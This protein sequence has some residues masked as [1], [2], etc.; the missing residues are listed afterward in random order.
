MSFYIQT[1]LY[2][3]G[4]AS[5]ASYTPDL[6]TSNTFYVNEGGANYY[7]RTQM[8]LLFDDALTAWQTELNAATPL[9]GTYSVSYD[10][11]TNRVTI[12]SSVAF[13]LGFIGN[14]ATIL[15][16]SSNSYA[17]ATSRTGEQVPAGKIK[18]LGRT[19]APAEHGEQVEVRTYRHQRALSI[20]W[21][22][23]QIFKIKLFFT[24][25]QVPA[26]LPK[27]ADDKAG[28]CLTGK[29][30]ITGLD[31]AAYSATNPDGFTEGYV[32]TTGDLETAGDTEGFYSMQMVLGV[33]V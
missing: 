15:G 23:I 11:A 5:S 7:V 30:R 9:S 21:G 18:L 17:S 13:S 8:T 14:T 19:M 32:V 3:E 33:V 12:S 1:Y 20:G 27:Y 6:A 16:F 29:V 28:Y 10:A 2:S 24:S 22:N 4:P 26:L 31:A 25:D